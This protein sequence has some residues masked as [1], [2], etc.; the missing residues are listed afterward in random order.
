MN[1]AS[2]EKAHVGGKAVVSAV[3]A[4]P[5]RVD[6]L[7]SLGIMPGVELRVQQ[8][9]PVVVVSCGEMV[10]AIERELAAFILVVMAV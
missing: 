9:R 3:V 4:S 7:A 1:A 5:Q 6:K 10:L 8:R 2:L